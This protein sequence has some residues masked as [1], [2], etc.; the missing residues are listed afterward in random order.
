MKKNPKVRLPPRRGQI[1][2]EIFRKFVNAIVSIA[3]MVGCQGGKKG[4]YGLAKNPIVPTE[5]TAMSWS[6]SAGTDNG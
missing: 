3:A 1:K 2:A 4:G 5:T 6:N